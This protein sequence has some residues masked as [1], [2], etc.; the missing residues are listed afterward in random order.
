MR[1]AIVGH[2]SYI[3]I[4]DPL[5]SSFS[6]QCTKVKFTDH[7]EV[8]LRAQTSGKTGNSEEIL[9][10]VT[11]TG[12][13][14]PAHAKASIFQPFT[15][16]IHVLSGFCLF[17]TKTHS[18]RWFPP[19]L[20][21]QADNSYTRKYGGSGLGLHICSRLAKMMN[22]E[23]WFEST[24]GKGSTFYCRV[25]VERSEPIV[26]LPPAIPILPAALHVVIID[27]VEE[28]GEKK[29]KKKN[30]IFDPILSCKCRT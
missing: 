20:L 18:F 15:Q 30:L 10:S 19:L 7:G 22:G 28:E 3:L 12:I 1:Y 27:S 14:V 2:V 9:I 25:I 11:D 6:L 17:G 24:Q 26:P 5:R 29:K 4:C 23:M 16:G 21:L 8:L 13:G